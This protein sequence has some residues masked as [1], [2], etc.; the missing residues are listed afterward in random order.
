M[1][2]IIVWFLVILAWGGST[3]AQ[4][5]SLG[6][7]SLEGWNLTPETIASGVQITTSKTAFDGTVYTNDG[8][9][10]LSL[11]TGIGPSLRNE[12]VKQLV[13]NA[14][15]TLSFDYSFL[16]GDYYN[17]KFEFIING[18]VILLADIAIVGN[19]G[20]KGW[21]PFTMV[22]EEGGLY[23]IGFRVT[24]SVDSAFQSYGLVR[25]MELRSVP[26]PTSLALIAIGLMTLL[27]SQ[28]PVLNRIPS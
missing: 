22:F 18:F 26:E 17:D 23:N 4:A 10:F 6:F 11:Q 24:N 12:I 16:G 15:D 13:I 14:R 28:R 8:D 7:E 20:D 3:Q 21:N 9:P 2:K 25:D 19:F 1:R 27:W 5:V